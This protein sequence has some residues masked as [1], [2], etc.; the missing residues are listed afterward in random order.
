MRS[1]NPT[2]LTLLRAGC[3]VVFPS[4]YRLLGDP[5]AGY[6]DTETE[7]GHDGL[8]ILDRDGVSLALG[9]ERHYRREQEAARKE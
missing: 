5:E 4:G 8:R 6:I 2:L 3:E 7:F 1:K 9:D